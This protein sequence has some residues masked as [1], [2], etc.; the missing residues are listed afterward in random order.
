MF[1]FD[2]EVRLP[3]YRHWPN[4]SQVLEVHMG[5]QVFIH[6]PALP[7]LGIFRTS[8]FQITAK[9]NISNGFIFEFPTRPPCEKLRCPDMIKYVLCRVNS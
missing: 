1:S 2:F 7:Y 6:S 8:N 9:W 3:S 4:P 5:G